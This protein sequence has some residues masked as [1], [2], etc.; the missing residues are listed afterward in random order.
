MYTT[1]LFDADETLLDFRR[2]ENSAL[3]ETFRQNSLP[4]DEDFL[5]SYRE[6][7]DGLWE[8]FN[9]GEISK[10]EVTDT[11]F[12]VFFEKQNIPLDGK[13]FN[14]LYLENLSKYGYALPGAHELC[15]KLYKKGLKL[16]IITN[17]IGFVQKKRFKESG[18]SRFFDGVFISEEV[19]A[20]KPSKEYFNFVYDN[21]DEKDKSKIIVVGDSL[22]ADIRGGKAY[23][24]VTCWYNVKD[25]AKKGESDFCAESFEDIERILMG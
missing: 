10:K 12:S 18:L 25:S 20:A 17:G 15:E 24:F 16:Y 14:G 21:I 5:R 2:S 1:V 23:G 19:G 11:R 9:K 3:T 13:I 6:I 8:R 22:S 7:N 4:Y